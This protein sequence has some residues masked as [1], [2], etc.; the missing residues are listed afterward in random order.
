MQGKCW[1]YIYAVGVIVMGCYMAISRV[2]VGNRVRFR[3]RVRVRLGSLD[4]GSV[5][6]IGLCPRPTPP[7]GGTSTPRRYARAWPHHLVYAHP[8]ARA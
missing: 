6:G 5:L 3:V 4:A 1:E 8:M 2:S 7:P